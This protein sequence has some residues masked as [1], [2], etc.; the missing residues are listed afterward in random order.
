MRRPCPAQLAGLHRRCAGDLASVDAV[1]L[2]PA[3]RAGGGDAQ[4][5]NG[6]GHRLPGSHQ[7]HRP[8]AELVGV[9]PRH[10]K[11]LPFQG[12][13]QHPK[14]KQKPA[15]GHLSPKRAADP[16]LDVLPDTTPSF[17]RTGVSDSPGRFTLL[18]EGSL[19]GFPGGHRLH[20][21]DTLTGICTPLCRRQLALAPKRAWLN[22][23]AAGHSWGPNTETSS[24][25]P[26]VEPV[27]HQQ[28]V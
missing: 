25:D 13:P 21:H 22:D 3:V 8:A 12:R 5:G 14:R 1:L 27:P 15:A 24:A 19:E 7:G 23:L 16:P 26:A 9:L 6:P 20:Q 10:G 2:D 4:I 28:V 18:W 17:P 11:S